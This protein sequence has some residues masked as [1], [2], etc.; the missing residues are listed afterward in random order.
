[1]T[2][3]YSDKNLKFKTPPKSEFRRMID[4]AAP[5][6]LTQLA[7]VA[8]LTTDTAMIGRLGADALAGASLSLMV[9]FLTWVFC[10][11]VVMATA[12]LASQAYGARDPRTVRRVIRQGLWV[13]ILITT[14]ALA[15]FQLTPAFLAWTGQPAETLP[16][17]DAYMSTLMWCLAPSIGFA[18]I[19]NFVSAL[20]R[21]GPALWVML[22]GVPL[23]A[24]L[25]YALIFGNFGLPRLE[26]VGA[27]IATSLVNWLMF[28][29][30][31]AIA[32][33][34]RP[35]SRYAVLGG[36]WRPD[37]FQFRRIFRIGLPIAGMSL[38]EAGFFIGAIFIVGQFGAMAI[39]ATMIALQMPHITFMIPMGLGQ[40]ATV[41][42]GQNVG[43]RNAPAA[44]RSGW[45]ALAL[46]TG[47][48]S[49][50]TV[51]VL[52]IPHTFASIYLDSGQPDS[53]EVLALA[54]YYLLFAA[55]FQAADGVQAVAAGALRGLNDTAIPMGIAAFSY[56]GVGLTT[57]LMLAYWGGFE[58]AGLWM[59]FVAG[60]VCAA[61]LLTA[62]FRLFHKRKYMPEVPVSEEHRITD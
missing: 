48:M 30:L 44:Y 50:M 59:G 51:I 17:A 38:L 4:L 46:A 20:S 34:C 11:G 45:Y 37:W 54:S 43:R 2:D 13:A 25:D 47:F 31:L 57:G 27:G 49:I 36:F 10:F 12:A 7:W 35:F 23:N 55:F 24:L 29:T 14:P 33:R 15:L 42:V 52:A 58:A 41:R 26:L 8:M 60:L 28:L 21:P 62:R 6:V 56:W 53:K 5:I 22:T 16:H 3:I 18:V 61:V 9:F 32:V 39:A 1:M 40:A 19:R